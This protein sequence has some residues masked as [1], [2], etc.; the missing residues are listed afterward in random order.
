[1]N[2]LTIGI[3]E[4][5]VTVGVI[6]IVCGMVV[7]LWSAIKAIREMT[8]PAKDLVARVDSIEEKLAR[9]KARLDE[10]E[11]AQKLLL[12]SM[13]FLIEHEASGGGANVEGFKDLKDDISNFLIN[14]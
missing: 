11:Q 12:R 3:N 7:T 5:A 2:D 4:L 14:R 13:L 10:Q 6:V 9:D 8:K 1:M